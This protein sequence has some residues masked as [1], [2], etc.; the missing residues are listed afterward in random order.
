MEEVFRSFTEADEIVCWAL[1]KWI[2]RGLQRM[3]GSRVPQVQRLTY[4]GG[5]VAN[6]SREDV[7]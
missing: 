5:V 6:V 7:F 1:A 2:V 3:Q 4:F